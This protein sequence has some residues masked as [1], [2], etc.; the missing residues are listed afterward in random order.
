V[1]A[2]ARSKAVR[3]GDHEPFTAALT[4]SGMDRRVALAVAVAVA[5]VL[6]GCSWVE[7]PDTDRPASTNATEGSDGGTIPA[8][9]LN[10]HTAVLANESYELDIAVTIRTPSR[11]RNAT[12]A[13]ASDPD[14]QRQLI[15]TRS[16]N[17]TLDRYVNDTAV[18]SRVETNGTTEYG[19]TALGNARFSM[20]HTDGVRIGRLATI[21]EFGQ[22]EPAGN[23]TRD[24]QRYAA[25]EL[26]SVN[27]GS[28]ATVTLDH[29]SGRIL[30]APNGVIRRATI[31]LRGTQR[32]DPFVYA[33]DY[34]ISGVGD[35]PV[36]PPAWLEEARVRGNST[37]RT[38]TPQNG[39]AAQ[40]KS[41]SG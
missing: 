1:V 2:V 32:G 22:F 40:T 39:T 8:G 18:F 36:Q 24:G 17:G 35:V 37:N 25:F 14:G 21:Y 33:I 13:V 23:V 19:R 34:R 41:V 9:R 5:M 6:A 4:L 29:S 12:V 26:A 10:D 38:G 15:R 28:N 7:Q 3:V 27:T 30:V 16:R 31:D 11:S 20:A